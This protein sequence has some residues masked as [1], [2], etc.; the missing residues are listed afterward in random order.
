MRL[1][2]TNTTTK[3]TAFLE[4]LGP[5]LTVP[6][7]HDISSF[8]GQAVIR[9]DGCLHSPTQTAAEPCYGGQLLECAPR[10]AGSVPKPDTFHVLSHD[11]LIP[12]IYVPLCLLSSFSFICT[13]LLSS[14]LRRRWTEQ[15]ECRVSIVY[16]GAHC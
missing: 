8:C 11:P 14:D 7:L 2:T 12:I 6:M 1:R 3:G 16:R 15:P 4:F 5:N 10:P 13:L 9:C